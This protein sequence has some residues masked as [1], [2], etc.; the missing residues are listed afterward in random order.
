MSF[1][2]ATV[3]DALA[4]LDNYAAGVRQ[5]ADVE[6][7]LRPQFARAPILAWLALDRGLRALNFNVE[8]AYL[9]AGHL[10]HI[11]LSMTRS[12][13]TR[14]DAVNAL[15]GGRDAWT[16]A[17]LL[18]RLDDAV[19]AVRNAA[20]THVAAVV[21]VVPAATLAAV[22]PLVDVLRHR[23]RS[24]RSPLLDRI[25]R[26]II[27]SDVVDDD[28]QP[29]DVQRALVRLHGLS[30]AIDAERRVAIGLQALRDN[31]VDLALA[32]AHGKNAVVRAGLADALAQHAS[33]RARVRGA[34]L[35]SDPTLLFHLSVDVRAE[36]RGAARKT[37]GHR[38]GSTA[39]DEQRDFA[40]AVVDEAAVDGA[41]RAV[42]G[43]LASL[44]EIGRAEDAGRISRFLHDERTRVQAEA[45]RALVGS[46]V[47]GDLVVYVDVL[48]DKLRSPKWRVAVEAARGL[49]WMPATQLPVEAIRDVEPT[50]RPQVKKLLAP[51]IGPGK[52]SC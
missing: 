5:S 31:D 30:D 12:G 6:N 4:R 45:V 17:A 16:L 40:R 41:G 48:I 32:I 36:V 7:D 9:G 15:R 42:I 18:L 23:E 10:G 25:R 34:Q 21:D 13:Y 2:I 51:L 27:A 11:A 35:V 44:A 52:W 39:A 46:N 26:L 24:G 37:I 50:A 49:A 1:D 29:L 20:A 8:L 43:G 28:T 47:A 22:L 19:I 38:F 3:R 33:G 14:L